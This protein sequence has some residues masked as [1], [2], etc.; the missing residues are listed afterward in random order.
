MITK[1]DKVGHNSEKFARLFIKVHMIF[2]VKWVLKSIE[3]LKGTSQVG[4][5]FSNNS[6]A[7]VR[8]SS[9]GRGESF[10]SSRK[11]YNR[12]ILIPILSDS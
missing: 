12:N 4:S 6:L 11:T 2:T 10:N 3:I 9:C 7:I 1:G 8:T 5:T